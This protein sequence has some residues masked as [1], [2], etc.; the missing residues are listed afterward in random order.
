MTP[1][2]AYVAYISTKLH[3]EQDGYNAFTYNFK[4]RAPFDSFQ[5]RNDRYLF[6]KLARKY[7]Q[8][9]E[10]ISFYVAHMSQDIMYVGDMDDDTYLSWRGRL[11]SIRYLFSREI[12][13][14]LG[15][16][17]L[18]FDVAFIEN[19]GG[20]PRILEMILTRDI[21]LETVV[22]LDRLLGLQDRWPDF[23]TI[24][25]PDLKLKIKKYGFFLPF[26][27]EK[28]FHEFEKTLTQVYK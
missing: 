2:E 6:E 5:K 26:D 4:T 28:Y 27:R 25:W 13:D 18:S 17:N 24:V 16:E 22:L 9:S 23:D 7:P 19:D 1:H 10:L 15:N 14:L 11:A 20:Y 21:S 3:F 12:Q 8:K